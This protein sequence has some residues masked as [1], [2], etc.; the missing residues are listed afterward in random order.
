MRAPRLSMN[1]CASAWKRARTMQAGRCMSQEFARPGSFLRLATVRRTAGA[2]PRPPPTGAIRK[3][4][5]SPS[6]PRAQPSGTAGSGM[7]RSSLHSASTVCQDAQSERSCS[8]SASAQR[9][10]MMRSSPALRLTMCHRFSSDLCSPT[11]TTWSAPSTLRPKRSTSQ[12]TASA[13]RAP[14]PAKMRSLRRQSSPPGAAC[15]WKDQD[16][17]RPP[18]QQGVQQPTGGVCVSSVQD[19]MNRS[20][21]REMRAAASSS[22]MSSGHVDS[23]GLSRIR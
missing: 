16:L 12:R 5:D 3:C 17:R 8:E 4:T 15:A 18:K 23:D 20:P 1:L 22:R 7:P 11:G 10:S 19:S 6:P 13:F 14:Q 21:M 2:P 9:H